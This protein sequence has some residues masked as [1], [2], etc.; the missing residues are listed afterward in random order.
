LSISVLEESVPS[1]ATLR[2]TYLGPSR[3]S[4]IAMLSSTEFSALGM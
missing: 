2:H 1:L 3:N 4:A